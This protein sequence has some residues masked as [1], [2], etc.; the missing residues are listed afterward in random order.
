MMDEP[1]EF[2]WA[3]KENTNGDP[4]GAPVLQWRRKFRIDA[5]GCFEAYWEFQSW[6]DVPVIRIQCQE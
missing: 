5:D 1:I 2:R 6:Q 3:Q 4:I